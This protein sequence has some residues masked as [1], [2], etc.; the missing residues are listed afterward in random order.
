M[1]DVLLNESLQGQRYQAAWDEILRPF[2]AE[3]EM[4]LFAAFRDTPSDRTDLL[5]SLK[6]QSNALDSLKSE[7]QTHIDTGKLARLQIDKEA[8]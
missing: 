2:F 1:S 6:M 4:Q 8:K 7:I 5:V 3:K